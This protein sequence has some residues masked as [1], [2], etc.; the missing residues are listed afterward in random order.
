MSRLSAHYGE[1]TSNEEALPSVVRGR[2]FCIVSYVGGPVPLRAVREV[3]L[4]YIRT[5]AWEHRQEAAFLHGSC[6]AS[7]N[8][9]LQ[10][11]SSSKPIPLQIVSVTATKGKVGHNLGSEPQP[12]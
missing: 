4:G 6:L 2:K 9:G 5:G 8:N 10:V 7:I 3:D 1:G 12:R 11:I